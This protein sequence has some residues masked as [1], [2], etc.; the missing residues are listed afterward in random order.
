VS[1]VDVVIPA[2]NALPYLSQAVESVLAQTHADL[3][4]FVVDDGSTDKT[5]AYVESI[6]DPRV[7][8]LYKENGG[9]ATARNVGIRASASPFVAVLDAD[10]VWY[11]HKLAAQLALLERRQEVGLVHGY[12][13]LIDADGAVGGSLEHDLRGEVFD[14]LLGGNL[15]NGSGSMVVVRRAVFDDVGLFREDFLIGEDW[16]MWLRV[17]RAYPVDYVPDH[18]MAIRIHDAS[19][20]RDRIKMADGHVMMFPEMVRSFQLRG[21]SRARLAVSCLAPAAYDYALAQQPK[22]SLATLAWL[23]RESPVGALRLRAFRFYAWVLL[24][25]L[26]E[27]RA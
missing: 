8:Y 19:M 9:Q 12:H 16:E 17:A 4:L 20:Q 15:V 3:E 1:T 18:L 25:A 11:P 24:M 27:L 7:H 2:Y 26:K 22:R 21:R 14:R 10:D 23:A 6:N 5:R 13:H